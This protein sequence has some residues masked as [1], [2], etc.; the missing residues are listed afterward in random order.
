MDVQS[1]LFSPLRT[2]KKKIKMETFSHNSKSPSKKSHQEYNNMTGTSNFKES[3]KSKK[4][5]K[6]LQDFTLPQMKDIVIS[7]TED[8]SPKKARRHKSSPGKKS[9]GITLYEKHQNGSLNNL[10]NS[11]QNGRHHSPLGSTN[12]FTSPGKTR[13]HKAA[14]TMN[15]DSPRSAFSSEVTGSPSLKGASARQLQKQ[16]NDSPVSDTSTKKS[17]RKS[18]LKQ[19][20][21]SPKSSPER[22]TSLQSPAKKQKSSELPVFGDTPKTSKRVKLTSPARLRTSSSAGSDKH[23]SVLNSPSRETADNR[24]SYKCP[25]DFTPFSFE[26]SSL[27]YVSSED[28][29]L[30]S[31]KLFLIKAPANFPISRLPSKIVLNGVQSFS[32]NKTP[33][34]VH[35]FLDEEKSSLTSLVHNSDTHRLE[36][37]PSFVGQIHVMQSL[38]VPHEPNTSSAPEPQHVP[39]PEGLRVRYTPFGSADPVC[40]SKEHVRASKSKK[41]PKKAKDVQADVTDSVCDSS[42]EKK[43]KKKKKKTQ[44]AKDVQADVTD[45]VCDSSKEKKEKKKKKKPQK[46]K[47]VQADVTDSVYDSSKEKKEKK[48]KKKTQKAKDVQADVTD[49]VCDSSKEKKEKKK[50]KKHKHS[51]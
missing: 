3:P 32:C 34:E 28:Y 21:V 42:K 30:D 11:L 46:A 43:E 17:S 16:A 37:G 1:S 24:L 18:I 6:S 40:F 19:E 4:R 48:K 49:S 50:K 36:Q 47:D 51:E 5:K 26:N 31:C 33:Y 27:E 7:M 20:D 12:E 14:D 2:P 29:S 15:Q 45:S 9:S 38:S 41:K 35:S 10:D 8:S 13:K 22:Y 44:K 39:F 25:E 23:D